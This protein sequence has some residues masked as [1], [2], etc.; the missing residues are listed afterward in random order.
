MTR[1][2]RL[3]MTCSRCSAIAFSSRGF[4]ASDGLG[5][6]VMCVLCLF[7]GVYA[8]RGVMGDMLFRA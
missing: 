7:L 2:M 6:L 8:A 3:G 4:A 5:R 1:Q